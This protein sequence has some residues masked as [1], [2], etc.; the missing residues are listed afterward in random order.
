MIR[1]RALVQGTSVGFDNRSFF[2]AQAESDELIG[3]VG[4]VANCSQRAVIETVVKHEARRQDA[5]RILLL[6]RLDS[7]FGKP[8]VER[9]VIIRGSSLIDWEVSARVVNENVVSIFDY[10]RNHRNSVSSTVAEFHDIARL[11][12]A[13]R[14]VVSVRDY[15]IMG[16]FV[17]LLSQAAHVIEIERTS[18]E[19]LRRLAA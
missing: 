16:N 2:I 19:A 9:D 4:A 17:G 1:A 18:D 7:A 13:P 10:A 14:R 8:R 12:A 15:E 6:N 11:E 5:D 3:A